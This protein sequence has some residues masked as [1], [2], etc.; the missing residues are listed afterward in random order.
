MEEGGRPSGGYGHIPGPRC[1]S[2]QHRLRIPMPRPAQ[3]VLQ[4]KDRDIC[5]G[6]LGGYDRPTDGL[7]DRQTDSP[8]DNQSV[9]GD[10]KVL[11]KA[12]KVKA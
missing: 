10:F 1:L 2:F 8:A 6:H 7:T 12:F 4:S 11:Y 3:Q 9:G 5:D